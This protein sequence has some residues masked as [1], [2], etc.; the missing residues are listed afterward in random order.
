MGVLNRYSMLRSD[1][2]LTG[3]F[4]LASGVYCFLSTATAVPSRT[5]DAFRIAL[6]VAFRAT[7]V[8]M[9]R[10]PVRSVCVHYSL[11]L[12]LLRG[13]PAVLMYTYTLSNSSGLNML[14]APPP[15]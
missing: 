1:V 6:Y 15:L 5:S 12:S 3:A 11:L 7:G 9:E 2:I 10:P 13:P 14:Y 8:R 4:S